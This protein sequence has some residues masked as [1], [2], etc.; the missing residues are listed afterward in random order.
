MFVK[1]Q[2]DDLGL[3]RVTDIAADL[4]VAIDPAEWVDVVNGVEPFFGQ[5]MING[6]LVPADQYD[7]VVVPVLHELV[8][9]PAPPVTITLEMPAPPPPDVPP[10]PEPVEQELEHTW[11]GKATPENIANVEESIRIFTF[12]VEYVQKPENF[13]KETMTLTMRFKFPGLEMLALPKTLVIKDHPDFDHYLNNLQVNLDLMKQNLV[14]MKEK[15][16]ENQNYLDPE[17]AHKPGPVEIDR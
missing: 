2:Q 12:M 1:V 14:T 4:S 6:Q 10:E 5:Y 13:D 9:P 17:L 7:A 11:F 8:P 16:A 3:Y 15:L